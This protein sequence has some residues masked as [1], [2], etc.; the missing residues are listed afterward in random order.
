MDTTTLLTNITGLGDGV[1]LVALCGTRM[2]VAFALLPLFSPDI[3]PALVRNAF[4]IAMG[5][6][7]LAL[8]PAV[9]TEGWATGHWLLLFGK[10]ALIG[11]A[12][13]FGIAAF[14]WAFE[15]AGQIVDTKV[16]TSGLQLTDPLS[17]N[18][19][20]GSAAILGR[21]TAA[22]FM[23]TGG[24]ML[25]VGVLL[26]SFRLWPVAQLALVPRRAGMVLFEQHLDS[27]LG[28]AFL[29]AAPVLIVMFAVDL[30]LGLVNRYAPQINLLSIS[31]SLKALASIAMWMLMLASL[32]TG[33]IDT[34]QVRLREALPGLSRLLQS[35]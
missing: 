27:L 35:S 8:Q 29:L 34:L 5:V 32:A 7:A 2:A 30:A 6:L 20:S 25:L 14:L 33:F 15:A 17:G 31:A 16:G 28:L 3:V 1:L 13:G 10:E 26:E 24:L 4:F 19:V 18:Q 9:R 12:I 11:A 21:L 22:L 23:A